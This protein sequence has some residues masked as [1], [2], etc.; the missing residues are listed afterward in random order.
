MRS[1][2]QEKGVIE[3]V[4]YTSNSMQ[5]SVVVFFFFLQDY[6]DVMS[7]MVFLVVIGFWCL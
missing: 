3:N 4:F 6:K 7:I 5:N 1:F 2:I